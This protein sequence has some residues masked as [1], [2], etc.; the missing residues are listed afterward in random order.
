MIS[1]Y[2]D[3]LGESNLLLL[4][5]RY[6]RFLHLE[7]DNSSDNIWEVL[8]LFFIIIIIFVMFIKNNSK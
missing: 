5:F 7:L 4:D 6:S 3:V 2:K 1:K 8:I